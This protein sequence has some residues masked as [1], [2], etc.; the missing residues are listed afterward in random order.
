MIPV[1]PR[2]ESVLAYGAALVV[3]SPFA[4][5]FAG[6][7]GFRA[8]LRLLAVALVAGVAAGAFGG[9][10]LCSGWRAHWIVRRHEAGEVSVE[11]AMVIALVVFLLVATL[12]RIGGYLNDIFVR[13]TAAFL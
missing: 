1:G 11:Y 12:T 8:G 6:A 3:G 10:A 9:A 4:L 2:I 5:F 7:D 13:L